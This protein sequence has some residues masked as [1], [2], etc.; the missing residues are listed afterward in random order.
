[1]T[2]M[3]GGG[4]WLSEVERVTGSYWW[5]LGGDGEMV[6]WRGLLGGETGTKPGPASLSLPG[7]PAGPSSS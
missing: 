7:S 4:C 1:M 3:V 2:G 5:L 6:R